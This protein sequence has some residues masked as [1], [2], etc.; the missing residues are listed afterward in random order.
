MKVEIGESLGY[1]FLRHVEGCW[2]VQANWKASDYWPKYLDDDELEREFVAIRNKLESTGSG[3]AGTFKGTAKGS[4]FLRQ[5]EIDIVGVQLDGSIHTVEVAFHEDGLHYSGN[6]GNNVLKK[7]LRTMLILRAYHPSDTKRH[8]CFASPK[9]TPKIQKDLEDV[10]EWL[11]REYPVVNW[12]LLTN[13]KFRDQFL[14][15]LQ[16]KLQDKSGKIADT[17]ELFVRSL[18]LLELMGS[19]NLGEGD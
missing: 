17:S 11:R 13:E 8:I 12:Q 4:T 2:L 7:M 9:V 6:T 16:D 3:F 18:Q 15:P 5:A 10:F 19:V 14:R 1:S